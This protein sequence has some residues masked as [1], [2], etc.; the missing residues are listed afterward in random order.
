MAVTPGGKVTISAQ[1][2]GS[3]ADQVLPYARQLLSFAVRLT[4]NPADAEDLVQDRHR[5]GPQAPGSAR[6]SSRAARETR[7]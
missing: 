5:R 4:G 2:T 6:P 1:P 7:R 3:F